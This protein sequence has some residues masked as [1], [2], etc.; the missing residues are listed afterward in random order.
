MD[1]VVLPLDDTHR[2]AL[3]ALQLR[4]TGCGCPGRREDPHVTVATFTG[5]DR[6]RAARV[7]RRAVGHVSPFVLRA[8][9]LGV[10]AGDDGHRTLHVQVVRGP[11]LAELHAA[12]IGALQG[13]GA[14]VAEWTGPELW[15]PHI[16]VLDEG[17]DRGLV[18]DAIRNLG[19]RHHPS[20]R[21]PVDRLVVV[22]SAGGPRAGRHTVDL[23]D[24]ARAS[25]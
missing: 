11:A 8:H 24:G 14:V 23:G 17:R 13:A 9:G 16:T 18:S 7:L 1:H 21:I 25:S 5:L 19:G 2:D 10:F 15:T 12:V 3:S 4:A 6:D 20:W 22:G